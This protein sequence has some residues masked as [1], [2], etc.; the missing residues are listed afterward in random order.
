MGS[1]RVGHDGATELNLTELNSTE[2]NW[3]YPHPPEQDLVS[4][5][6][7]LSHQETSL[8]LLSLSI[9]GHTELKP[10]SQKTNQTD[11]MDHSL[12]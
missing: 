3:A 8:S 5:S 1:Q 10:Q 4:P 6:V 2:L 9:R 11:H 7:S 12:F